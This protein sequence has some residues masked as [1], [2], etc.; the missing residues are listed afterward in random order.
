MLKQATVALAFAS[1]PLT[2]SSISLKSQQAFDGLNSQH[3]HLVSSWNGNECWLENLKKLNKQLPRAIHCRVRVF[4]MGCLSPLRANLPQMILL[5]LNAL[6]C[7]VY[8]NLARS[9]LIALITR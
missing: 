7:T 2:F 5:M 4:R 9:K 1:L 3:Q 8:A 6:I